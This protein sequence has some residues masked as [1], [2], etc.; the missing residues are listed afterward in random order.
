MYYSRFSN[1][2]IKKN[3][4]IDLFFMIIYN[5]YYAFPFFINYKLG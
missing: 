2:K 5:H 3:I 4:Y 1:L